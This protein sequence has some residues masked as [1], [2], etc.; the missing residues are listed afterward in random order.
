[1][2][3]LLVLLLA[4]LTPSSQA[5]VL[6]IA[7][8]VNDADG[9]ARPVPRH[10]LLVSDNPVTA[11]PQRVVTTI[12]G[13]AEI[14]LAP[15]NYTIESDEP[16]IFDGKSYQWVQTVDVAAGRPA[17]LTL[18]AANA[19]TETAAPGAASPAIK[20][21]SAASNIL[22]DWQGSVFVIWTPKQIGAGFLADPRGLVLTSQRLI[23]KATDV[24]VQLSASMKIPARVIASDANANVAVLWIDPKVAAAARPVR[25]AAPAGGKPAV[26]E[27]DDVFAVEPSLRDRATLASGTITR[28]AAHTISSNAH[29]DRD[30]A[31]VPLFN[32]DGAVV[33]LTTPGEAGSEAGDTSSRAVRIEDASAALAEAAKKMQN[34]QPPAGTLPV[35]PERPLDDEKL[36][37]TARAR[38]GSLSAYIVPASDFDVALITPVLLYGARH[39]GDRERSPG[40]ANPMELQPALRAL[41]EFGNWADY[42]ADYPPVLLIRVTPKLSEAFWTTVARGAASTQGVQIPAIKRTKSGFARMRAFCGETEVTPIHPFRIEQHVDEKTTIEEGLYVFEPGALGAQCG[43]VKLMLYSEK[44]PDKPDTRIVDPKVVQQVQDDFTRVR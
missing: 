32:A 3:A 8:T 14:R 23:G 10:A 35:E 36:R 16:L 38:G 39:R 6:K 5:V 2:R 13:I 12:D 1:M 9:R 15:G 11:A 30:N 44:E 4:L 40:P 42:V 7:V 25:L 21:A 33:A 41:E 26:S 22:S 37:E 19:L 20:A 24:E 43:T 29:I 18:N 28:V 17:S 31:G 34:A 27:G